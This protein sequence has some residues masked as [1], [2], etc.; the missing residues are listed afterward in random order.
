MPTSIEP[1]LQE[2]NSSTTEKLSSNT[3][4][5]CRN[6]HR[7]VHHAQ[8]WPLTVAVGFPKLTGCVS[9]LSV[10]EVFRYLA[11]HIR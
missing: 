2:I 3:A 10:M 11:T 6:Q 1:H 4:V 9:T 8:C 5:E 7:K